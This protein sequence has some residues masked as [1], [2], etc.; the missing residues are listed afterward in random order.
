MKLTQVSSRNYLVFCTLGNAVCLLHHIGLPLLV[1]MENFFKC[2]K[3]NNGQV[4]NSLEAAIRN[5]HIITYSNTESGGNVQPFMRVG[6]SCE[7]VRRD[8]PCVGHFPQL[9]APFDIEKSNRIP[10]WSVHAQALPDPPVVGIG[11]LPLLGLTPSAFLTRPEPPSR[12]IESS[13]DRAFSTGT[14][15]LA[16]GSS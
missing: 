8:C 5:C 16:A 11:R 10:G 13:R 6:D 15:S 2:L 12:R 4:T 14:C 3:T 9:D 1:L 7:W